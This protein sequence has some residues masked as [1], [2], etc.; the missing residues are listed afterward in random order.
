MFAPDIVE[1]DERSSRAQ[2]ER[3]RQHAAQ[4]QQRS[5]ARRRG[6]RARS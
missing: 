2:D 4:T 6:N 1:H 5:D 3:Q